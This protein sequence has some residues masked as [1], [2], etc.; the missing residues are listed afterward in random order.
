MSLLQRVVR[1]VGPAKLLAMLD[2]D[3]RAALPYVWALNARPKQL[4]PRNRKWRWWVVQS[5]R[6][7]GKT[8]LAAEW[9]REKAKRMPG[10]IGALVGQTPDEVRSIQI[11]GPA[12]L[13]AISPPHERP[14]WRPAVGMLTWPLVSGA[15][16][17]AQVFSGANPASLRGPQHHWA[18]M[19]EFAKYTRARETFDNLNMGMRLTYHG[20]KDPH[21]LSPQCAVTTTPRPIAALRDLV[22]KP[23]AVVTHGSTFENAANLDESFIA[24]MKELLGTRLGEQELKGVLLDDVP[25]AMWQRAWFERPG[26]RQ[27]IDLKQF[28]SIVVAIDPAVSDAETSAETGII[29]MGMWHV[30]ARRRRYHV[31]R[32]AS[33]HGTPSQRM[34]AAI[35]LM[36]ELEA[37]EFVVETNNGGDWIPHALETE[38]VLM[39]S[40]EG[41]AGKLAGRPRIEAV[42]ASRGKHVRAEPISTMFEQVGTVTSE[43]GLEVLEDQLVT[44]SPLLG[45][46]SPDRLDALV[47]AATRLSAMK[48]V[49][50]Y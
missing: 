41:M 15:P 26:Y 5:G 2:G 19:D 3:M 32:D 23:S 1:K 35:N 12:G 48:R 10:S 42:T 13:L 33:V 30:D 46:K 29:A 25:G 8:R 37:D 34:R 17:T 36:V 20:A 14:E 45:E 44:W 39:Q 4:A 18:W 21:D 40:E 27:H 6:G 9:V 16:T 47:W 43:P 38:W 50:V 11:E 31:L 28:D 7:F 22:K 24:E 49:V